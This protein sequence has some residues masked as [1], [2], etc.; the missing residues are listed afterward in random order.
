MDEKKRI[1]IIGCGGMGGGHAIAIGSG[2]GN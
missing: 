1:A 2:T